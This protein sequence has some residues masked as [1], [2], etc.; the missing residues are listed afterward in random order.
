MQLLIRRVKS[1]VPTAA[2][3]LASPP[4]GGLWRMDQTMVV[5]EQ[6]KVVA[7]LMRKL[8]VQERCAYYDM[9]EA[10]GGEGSVE[11]WWKAGLMNRDLIHPVAL[12]GDLMGFLLDE[13]LERARVRGELLLAKTARPRRAP[14]RRLSW[15]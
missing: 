7:A 5:R 10:M 9:Q 12:G 6:T 8:A 3:L 11:R 2:C 14:V 15:R 13:A 4:D 1:A